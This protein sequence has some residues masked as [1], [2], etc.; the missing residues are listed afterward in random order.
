MQEIVVQKNYTGTHKK[1]W[2]VRRTR[3]VNPYVFRP[4]ESESKVRIAK[5]ARIF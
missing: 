2:L 3:L 5:L 4:A 1:K